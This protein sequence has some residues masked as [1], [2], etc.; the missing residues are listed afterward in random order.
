MGLYNHT[1]DEATGRMRWHVPRKNGLEMVG[2]GWADLVNKAY[3]LVAAFEAQHGV[4]V[5]VNQVKEKFGGLR[6]YVAIPENRDDLGPAKDDLYY[7]IHNLEQ[8]SLDICETCGAP[9]TC[10][11]P[12]GFW[13]KTLCSECSLMA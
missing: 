10:R 9:G 1:L 3:D 12:S 4:S 13:V 11:N 8:A 2:K 7:S 5:D 6:F